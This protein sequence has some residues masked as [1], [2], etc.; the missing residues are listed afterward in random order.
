MKSLSFFVNFAA[1][2]RREMFSKV[3]RELG[4][5]LSS[6]TRSDTRLEA[7]MGARL[8]DRTT[9]SV[10]LTGEGRALYGKSQRLPAEIEALDLSAVSDNNVPAGILRIGAPVGYGVHVLLPAMTKLRERYP[11]IE[12]DLRLSD[13]RVNVYEEGLDS[14]IRFGALE[15]STLIAQRIGEK[16]LVLCASPGYLA[17]HPRIRS[18]S[19]IEHHAV[20]AFRMPTDG[21]D[22]PLHFCEHG[23]EVV[24]RPNAAMRMDHGEGL[25]RAA[26]LGA[27]VVQVPEFLVLDALVGGRLVEVLKEHRPEPLAVS[28]VLTGARVRSGRVRVMVEVLKGG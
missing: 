3:A 11:N 5:V 6:L 10:T 13:A 24:L 4:L 22:R 14:V 16:A 15:D 18:V 23:R 7:E 12:I 2:A 26:E 25:V 9:R 21:R 19:D 17:S 1:G 20:I 8:F 27:G 28:L